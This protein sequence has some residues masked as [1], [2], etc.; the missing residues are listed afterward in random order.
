MNSEEGGGGSGGCDRGTVAGEVALQERTHASKFRG[1]GWDRRN[2]KWHVRF[3]HNYK[4]VYLG[5]FEDEE[6][7]A[8]ANDR[9]VV[10]FELHGIVR[11]KPTGGVHDEQHKSFTQFR[12]GGSRGRV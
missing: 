12:V 5:C 6:E 8:R 10:W 11:T 1:V 7:A 9:M 2:Q 4:E 3:K